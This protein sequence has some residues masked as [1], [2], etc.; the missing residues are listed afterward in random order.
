MDAIWKISLIGMDGKRVSKKYM[1]LTCLDDDDDD[2]DA[3]FLFI[4]I[5]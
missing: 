5:Y 3:V 2:D 1:Q 4:F